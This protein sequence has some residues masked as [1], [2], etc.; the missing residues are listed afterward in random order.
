M[1]GMGFDRIVITGASSGIG[2]ALAQRLARPGRHLGLLGRDSER[3]A[4]T[5]AA[6]NAK[7]ASTETATLDVTD[8]ETLSAFVQ[9][10]ERRDPIDLLIANAGL[11]DGRRSGQVVEDGAAAR[12]VL[13]TN[14]MAAIDIVHAV[15][16]GMR[17]RHRGT[18]VLVSSL[19]AFVPLPDAPAYSAS[20]AGLL[21]YG[22]ALREAVA[23]EG[24]QVVVACPG[25]VAT[26]MAKIHLGARPDEITA[27]DA[28]VR[29]LD[30]IERNRGVIAFPFVPSWLSRLSLLVPE[31]LRRRGGRS[32]RFHV[33]G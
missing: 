9:A 3:L 11:L 24:V 17:Q 23:S 21:F 28:A 33:D 1:G 14:L 12:R 4:A 27:A 13:D 30:G 6:C 26:R 22:L 20:K 15:L 19:A 8:R 18:I 31:W 2:A 25:Y 16:P 10:F 32:T 5:A 7:G 29:I